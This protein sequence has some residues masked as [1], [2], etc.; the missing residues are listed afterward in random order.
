MDDFRSSMLCTNF[1]RKSSPVTLFTSASLR[2]KSAENGAQAN[3]SSSQLPNTPVKLHDDVEA[4]RERRIVAPPNLLP[5]RRL[6]I[7]TAD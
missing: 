6:V 4:A 1:D 7:H 3:N 2:A 5:V